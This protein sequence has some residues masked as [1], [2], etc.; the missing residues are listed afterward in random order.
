[1]DKTTNFTGKKILL[2]ED[3]PDIANM[4]LIYLRECG[5]ITFHGSDMDGWEVLEEIKK[6]KIPT[7][8]IML[9]QIEGVA[10]IIRFIRAGACDYVN[11]PFDIQ[12]LRMR[13]ERALEMEKTINTNFMNV[14]PP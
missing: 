11:K 6:R 13:I 8:I 10:N 14:F 9:T 5:Y 7:R 12:H 3:E 1:M 4:I 2:I